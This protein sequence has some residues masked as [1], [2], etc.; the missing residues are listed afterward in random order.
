MTGGRESRLGA[1]PPVDRVRRR[2]AW[3]RGSRRGCA[4]RLPNG[5]VGNSGR[6]ACVSLTRPDAG[7]TSD[8][9]GGPLSSLTP[10]KTRLALL[11]LA[12]GGFG[13]GTTEFVAMGVLPQIAQGLEPALWASNQDAAI[14]RAGCTET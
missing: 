14:S 9:D 1:A 13:I 7:L 6:L 5:K 11:A 8:P 10:A 12:L 2:G 4:L 3:G